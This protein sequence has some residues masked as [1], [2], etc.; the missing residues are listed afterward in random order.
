M[1]GKILM[2]I[3]AA[4]IKRRVMH[5]MWLK[6]AKSEVFKYFCKYTHIANKNISKDIKKLANLL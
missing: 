3:N 5:K 4:K 2:T 1:Q 6:A